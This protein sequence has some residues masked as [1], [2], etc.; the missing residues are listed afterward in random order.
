MLVNEYAFEHLALAH[1]RQLVRET[2]WVRVREERLAEE[3]AAE[4]SPNRPGPSVAGW[5]G[6]RWLGA[7][8]SG[9]AGHRA[10]S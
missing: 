1:E 2:E 5:F 6:A 7:V 10:R 3:R 8:W 4:P 9:A